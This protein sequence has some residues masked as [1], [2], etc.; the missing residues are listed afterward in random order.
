MNL[1]DVN[2]LVHAHRADSE[3]H[4]E[5]LDWLTA[6]L[7]SEEG[8]AVSD[9][10]LSGCVRIVTHPKVFRPP[11]PVDKALKF[12]QELRGHPNVT[13]LAPGP[14]H[15]DVFVR[16]CTEGDARGNLA[17]GAFH[18]ALAIETGCRWITTDRDFARF[19]GL[20]WDL[21]TPR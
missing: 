18:A 9:L 16:L 7:R 21:P 2:V 14:R 5:C 15:W 1:V 12:V 13:V 3:R 6:A 19:P 20:D 4:Q 10:V 11:S 17:S 8:L